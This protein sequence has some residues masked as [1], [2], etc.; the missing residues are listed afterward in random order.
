MSSISNKQKE[1][2]KKMKML[3]STPESSKN[4][5]LEYFKGLDKLSR[6][7]QLFRLGQARH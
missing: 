2:D 7:E 4:F 3:S 1:N 5:K 6:C